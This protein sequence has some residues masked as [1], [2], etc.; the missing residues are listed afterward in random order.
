MDLHETLI[1]LLTKLGVLEAKLDAKS[2]RD[3]ERLD[4]LEEQVKDHE[5]RLRA[6]EA[7]PGKKWEDV[8]MQV[9]IA[10]IL[11]I[12]SFALGRAGIE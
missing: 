3:D 4:Q 2:A 1:A 5:N 6:N 11:A 7:K 12:I 10:I 9:I 8:K